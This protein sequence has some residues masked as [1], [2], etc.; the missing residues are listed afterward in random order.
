MDTESIKEAMLKKRKVVWEDHCYTVSALIARLD[1]NN[2]WFTQVE[3]TDGRCVIIVAPK[4]IRLYQ[5]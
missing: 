2:K 1:K 3:I 4:D 5:P